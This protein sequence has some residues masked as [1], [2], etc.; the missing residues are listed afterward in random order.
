[1]LSLVYAGKPQLCL[2]PR[3]PEQSGQG[4][5][6]KYPYSATDCK[7]CV[8]KSHSAETSL[9]RVWGV[10][11]HRRLGHRLARC[12]TAAVGSRA[13]GSQR[14]RGTWATADGVCALGIP[15][16]SGSTEGSW[17]ERLQQPWGKGILGQR[18]GRAC[19]VEQ[20]G[21]VRLL[22]ARGY[23]SASLG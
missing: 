8:F 18:E 2:S 10:K 21:H 5:L 15:L 13:Q 19:G 11:S 1:V 6:A 3:V 12:H 4:S 23:P 20:G 14:R 7:A 17:Q 16:L 9:Q 22:E